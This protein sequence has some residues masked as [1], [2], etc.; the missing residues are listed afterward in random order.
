MVPVSV[1]VRILTIK[2]DGAP[3]Q[4]ANVI[5]VDSRCGHV[6][7]TVGAITSLLTIID[8][9]KRLMGIVGIVNDERS[10]Q[11]VAVLRRYVGMIPERAGLRC[12]VNYTFLSPLEK[13]YQLDLER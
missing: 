6:S 13:R 9:I 7:L 10:S 12:R 2:K 3:Y 8:V 11:A 1:I 4:S 5:T